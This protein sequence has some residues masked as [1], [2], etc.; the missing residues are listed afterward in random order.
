MGQGFAYYRSAALSTSQNVAF[1]KIKLQMPL[2]ALVG[3]GGLGSN[4]RN[5]LEALVG[6]VQGG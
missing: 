3:Q 4:M 2:F 6:N 1:G 5:N